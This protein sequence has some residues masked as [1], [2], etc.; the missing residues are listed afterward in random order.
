MGIVNLTPDSFSDGGQFA[1]SEE[2]VNHALALA[3]A[4]ATVLD[5]GAESTRPGAEPLSAERELDRLLP[6]L[7][8]LTGS[9]VLLS[10]DTYKAEV[11][12]AALANGAHVI[13][14][15]TGLRD[16]EMVQVCADSSAPV[17][18]MHMQGTPQTMQHKPHYDDAPAEVFGMLERTAQ[19][20][21]GAGV[22][23]VMLDPGIGFGKTLAHNLALMTHLPDLVAL[24]Y[25][26]L[27][28]VSRKGLLRALT[29]VEDAPAR[30]P[31]SVAAHLWGA[32][33]GVSMVRVHNVAAHVQALKVWAALENHA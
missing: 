12:A 29:G 7:R 4:G 8:A 24:G 1:S 15:V 23:S 25:P 11:A 14:D 6:V 31:A 10:V 27:L 33:Q 2:A 22:P 30:D 16:P 18:I 32:A 9:G 28:G 13:N 5:L 19:Y 17:I 21:L 20:A 26:V 3:S